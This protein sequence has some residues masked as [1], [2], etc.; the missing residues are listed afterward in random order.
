MEIEKGFFNMKPI[1]YQ[2]PP[3]TSLGVRH[4]FLP[5]KRLLKRE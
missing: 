2:P 3:Q 5:D 1:A 4:A